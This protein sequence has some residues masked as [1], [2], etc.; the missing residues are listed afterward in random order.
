MGVTMASQGN[1]TMR[2]L[3]IAVLC[4]ALAG[5]A[6]SRTP[7][8]EA[9]VVEPLRFTRADSTTA[10]VTIRRDTGL[11]STA[12]ATRIYVDGTLAAYLSAGDEVTLQIPA[13]QVILG[14]EPGPICAGGLLEQAF[15]FS[16]GRPMTF[17]VSYDH[18]GRMAL[19]P[20]A[21]R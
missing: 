10:P 2:M 9:N 4:A 8:A 1:V 5:C 21:V 18:T 14:A 12:C 7:A 6:T 15:T 11:M 16:P 3:A 19:S 17:R 13:G 20:T